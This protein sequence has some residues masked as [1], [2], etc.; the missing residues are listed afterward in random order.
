MRPILSSALLVTIVAI[1]GC[2]RINNNEDAEFPK[3][4][5]IGSLSNTF[6]VPSLNNDAPST[7]NVIY[8]PV[9]LF[10]WNELRQALG[11]TFTMEKADKM[12]QEADTTTLFKSA[13]TPGEYETKV[14]AD[15][16]AVQLSAYFKKALPFIETMDTVD[17]GQPFAFYGYPIKAFGMLHYNEKIAAQIA[18]LY[19]RTNDHFIIKITPK[20]QAQEV[21]LAKGLTNERTLAGLLAETD[22]LIKVGAAEQKS[23]MK[24]DKY[25]LN[26]IDQVV[27]P[28]LRFNLE[29]DYTDF[30]GT[31][32]HHSKKTNT[33][34]S[35][36]QRTAFVLDEHGAKVESEVTV[37][38]DSMPDINIRRPDLSKL[39][40]F[41]KPFVVIL[42][43]TGISQ[44]YL[45]MKIENT[46]LMVK[47]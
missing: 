19:Y 16:G 2:G 17:K 27:I 23:K 29:K 34:L 20:D 42:R 5:P 25:R 26:P 30:A 7:G 6:F 28:V 46:E 9:F 35:A 18:I 47:R 41:D 4:I 3:V 22:K 36:T 40:W 39:L 32:L 33:L 44:P 13:L 1:S 14:N 45:M 15:D 12:L 10:A 38:T 37:S 21:I 31:L 43:K 24:E 8:T 11:G